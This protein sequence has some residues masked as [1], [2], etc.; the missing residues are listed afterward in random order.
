MNQDD[1]KARRD[2]AWKQWSGLLKEKILLDLKIHQL[3]QTIK[4]LDYLL[5]EKP[6]EPGELAAMTDL[7]GE[8]G[9]TGAIRVLLANS[10]LPLSPVE[11]RSEL[12]SHG[13]DLKD[14][15][16]AMAV[17][18]NTLKRLERQD[19]ITPVKD[20]DGQVTGYMM[21]WVGPG[22]AERSG[23]RGDEKP[24]PSDVMRAAFGRPKKK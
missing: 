1:I 14:Y 23:M 17:I 12:V 2:E 22:S 18:H 19:E 16:N 3:S 13:F 5:Q 4:A 7:V 20:A 10:K 9:I 11:I 8:S 15:A 21:R 24:K 6:I